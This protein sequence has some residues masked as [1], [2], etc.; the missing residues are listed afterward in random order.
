MSMVK[1]RIAVMYALVLVLLSTMVPPFGTVTAEG[2]TTSIAYE[3]DQDGN[4]EGW[5][6]NYNGVEEYSVSEGSLHLK[7]NE[8]DPYWYAPNRPGLEATADQTLTLRMRATNGESLAIYFDTDRYP[9]LAEAKRLI[10]PIQADGEYHEYTIKPGLHPNWS[11]EVQNLRIDLE[12]FSS[13]PAEVSIDYFRIEERSGFGYEFNGTEEG[14][15]VVQDVYALEPGPSSLM[16]TIEGF[17]PE[18][19]AGLVDMPADSI[20]EMKLRTRIEDPSVESIRVAFSTTDSPDFIPGQSLDLDVTAD[21]KYHEYSLNLWEH[22][23][24]T[25]TITGIRLG[26]NGSSGESSLW[27]TDYIRFNSVALPVFDWNTDGDAQGWLPIND[28]TSFNIS[29]GMLITQV[30]GSDPH[31]GNENLEGIIGERDKNLRVRMS[32]TAGNFVSVFFATSEAPFYAEA[33]RFDFTIEA[34]GQMHEYLVPV[35]DHPE[36]KG[37]VLKLRMDLEGGNRDGAEIR[38][39]SVQFISSPA[40]AEIEIKRSAPY[41]TPGEEA[42]ITASITNTGGKTFFHPTVDWLEAAG[43]QL[44]DGHGSIPIDSLPPGAT[45][46]VQWKVRAVAQQAANVEVR[47][48]ADGYVHSRSVPLPVVKSES[49]M[50]NVPSKLSAWVDPVSGD[51]VLGNNNIRLVA[52]KSSYGFAQYLIYTRDGKDWQRMSTTQ[53]FASATIASEGNRL[54]SVSFTPSKV[55]T[56]NGKRDSS[57]IFTGT[58]SDS[59]GRE[60][61]ATFEFRLKEGDSRIDIKQSIQSDTPAE[62]F[63][64]TGPV[65]NVGQ[66]SFGGTKD[67]ALFPGLE[68]LVGDE[69][70]SSKLDVTTPAY[71]RVVPHPY[72]VTVPLMAVRQDDHLISLSWDPLQKWDGVHDLPAAKFAS[73]NWVENQN[74]HL[75]GLAAISAVNGAKENKDLAEEPYSLAAGQ[76]LTLTSNIMT[77]QADSVAEAVSL[78]LEADGL[79]KVNPVRSFEEAVDLGLDAYLRTYWDPETKA[80]RHVNIIDWGTEPFP[81]NFVS[82]SL[83]GMAEPDRQAEVDSTIAEALSAME[84]KTRLGKPDFHIPQFQAPFYVGNWEDSLAGMKSTMQAYMASQN[85]SGAWTYERESEYNPPLGQN[86]TPMLGDSALRV[87][88]LLK[89]A[90]MTGDAEAEAAAFKGLTALED[91]GDVPRASQPWE[92]PLHT[93]DILAAGHMTGVYVE[94]YKLTGDKQYLKKA[95]AWA[96]RGLPFIY[97]WGVD[98]LPMMTYGTIPIFGASAYINSWFASPVQWNGMVYGY[99]LLEL[100]RYDKSFPWKQ[101]AEGILASA[102]IQ[103]ASD[104]S[105]TWRGGYPDNWRLLSNSRS[106]TVMIN[107]EEIVKNRFMLQ[108]VEGKG[109]NPDFQT[110]RIQECP[111]GKKGGSKCTV[112]AV[113]SLAEIRDASQSNKGDLVSFRLSYVAGETTYVV[114]AGR[115]QPK[116]VTVNGSQLAVSSDL[117]NAAAGWQYMNEEGLLLLKINHRS[118]DEVKLYY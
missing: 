117:D 48:A 72:K 85:E 87:K 15:T 103:Q 10:I 26:L 62:L 73:P 101:V 76:S 8:N 81:A 55:R 49:R 114:V 6:A 86:G 105:E 109:P 112:T 57:L 97:N 42:E 94:A 22:P 12:P 38:L 34:D 64:M 69:S 51:A 66:G 68:W 7:L 25:G 52:S 50:R 46:T 60:W 100:S 40:Q 19:E 28:V 98:E 59:S 90:A 32:A 17:E 43:L 74:N 33:R 20:G 2:G 4:A 14:W 36:W 88:Q 35:G 77:A 23:A 70:S 75:M 115:E 91:M 21:G 99:E 11:G 53:P 24:W 29:D 63:N 95:S 84:D 18:L 107:P 78:T 9:G 71:L 82:L 27:E 1:L 65:L 16:A 93:P 116:K 30:T 96:T 13:V 92:V 58:V 67:E 111:R 5:L 37:K 104:A 39:D 113:T 61:A 45:T 118:K 110:V 54:E 106:D 31:F 83:L 108:Y 3:F 80:W 102:E 89:Y 41:L 44:I 56:S 47:L 79:P